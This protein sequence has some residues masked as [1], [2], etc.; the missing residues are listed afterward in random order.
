[1]TGVK[2]CVDCFEQC[3]AWA[4]VLTALSFV[5][6]RLLEKCLQLLVIFIQQVFG[7]L[8]SLAWITAPIVVL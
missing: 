2:E 5:F 3:C 4:T 6:I 8:G 1:L 7:E